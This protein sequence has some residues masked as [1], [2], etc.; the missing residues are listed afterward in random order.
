MNNQAKIAIYVPNEEA[1]QFLLFQEYYNQF[2]LLVEHGVFD[3]RNGSVVLHFDK[4]GDVLA[5]NRAD[6]LYSKRHEAK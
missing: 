4:H 1:Q 2:V 3:V 5:I 6:I